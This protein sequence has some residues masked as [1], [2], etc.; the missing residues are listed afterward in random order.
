MDRRTSLKLFASIAACCYAGRGAAQSMS[1]GCALNGA[2]AGAF[3]ADNALLAASGVDF[4]DA[5]MPI[6]IAILNSAFFVSPDFAF[7]DD[8]SGPN[9][10]ATPA[11]IV[12]SSPHGS[13]IFGVNLLQSEL[14]K[15][16]WGA[17]IAGIA[18]HE[19]AHISQF[20]SGVSGATWKKELHA[21][22]MAGWYL[23]A[24]QLAGTHVVISGLGESVFSKGDFAFNHP[25]HHG[26]PAQ[27]VNAM[28]SGYSHG[29]SGMSAPAVF[30][31]ARAALGI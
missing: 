13:V 5:L 23:G 12:A 19:W 22:H 16:W 24:K 20:H 27:R 31:N 7:F 3:E 18:A 28:M 9:A 4:I 8:S 2:G 14:G 1:G 21:D 29:L 26:T 17:A 10:F 11:N 30:T 15:V 25:S 6:E